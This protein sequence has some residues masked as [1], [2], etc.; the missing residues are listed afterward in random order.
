MNAVYLAIHHAAQRSVNAK[1]SAKNLPTPITQIAPAKPTKIAI[2]HLKAV[3]T[4]N[5]INEMSCPVTMTM[6]VAEA[7]SASEAT[8]AKFVKLK[9]AAPKTKIVCTDT[10]VANNLAVTKALDNAPVHVRQAH[11]AKQI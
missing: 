8:I 5:A 9:K 3:P 11:P 2:I 7:A 4:A 10:S 6:I 1:G